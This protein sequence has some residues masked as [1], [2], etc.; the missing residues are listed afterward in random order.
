MPLD[1]LVEGD[2]FA[3]SGERQICKVWGCVRAALSRWTG[4]G[5]GMRG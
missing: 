3:K 5:R 4:F 1:V 2:G